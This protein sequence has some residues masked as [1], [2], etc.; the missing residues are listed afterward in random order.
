MV[1]AKSADDALRKA[2]ELLT[3][4]EMG[5][6]MV[7]DTDPTRRPMGIQN[8]AV[9]GRSVT[10]AL[11]NL[12]TIV[13]KAIFDEWYNPHMEA[14]KSDPIFEYFRNLRNEILKEGPPRTSSLAYVQ[15]LDFSNMSKLQAIQPPG[16]K[17]FFIGD[18][19]GGS[20]WIV[21]LP[22]GTEQ[23]FYVQ[24]P[25]EIAVTVTLHLSEY[26]MSNIPIADLCSKYV[27]QL[28]ALVREAE[29]HFAISAQ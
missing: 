22:D 27:D 8:V 14:M 3:T 1:E 20:G 4:A 24:F 16:A 28:E 18:A 21:E 10:F 9:F 23:K 26:P 7:R 2:R 5:L 6:A 12:R 15:H 17:N 29:A 19:L 11:Q 13:G 25:S